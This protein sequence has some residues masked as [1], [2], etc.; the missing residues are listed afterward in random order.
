MIGVNLYD[1]YRMPD[2]YKA[3]VRRLVEEVWTGSQL[4]ALDEIIHPDAQPPHGPWDLP[5]G[6]EGFRS[7]VGMIR[8]SFPDLTRSIEDM[9]EEGDRLALY[10]RLQGTHTGNGGLLPYPPTGERWDMLGVTA[11]RFEGGKIVE[12][13]WA[14]NTV[15]SMF[16]SVAKANVRNIF[17]QV[18]NGNQAEEIGKYY[19][20]EFLYHASSGAVFECHEG[21]RIVLSEVNQ[22]LPGSQ[23]VIESQVSEGDEVSTRWTLHSGDQIMRSGI[24]LIRFVEGLAVEEWETRG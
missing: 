4:E 12:E 17:E 22:A 5:T 1:E 24:S 10:Y 8:A 3:I 18:W 11:F 14:V 9:V 23:F 19:A 16:S 2:N 20:P 21:V 15:A 13:P 7:F 6:P